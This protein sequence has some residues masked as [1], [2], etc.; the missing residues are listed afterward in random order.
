[1]SG[2]SQ[3]RKLYEDRVIE[4][5]LVQLGKSV[6]SST[7][8][9]TQEELRTLAIRTRESFKRCD[10]ER[11]DRYG[12]HLANIYGTS[13]VSSTITELE[14]INNSIGFEEK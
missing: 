7:L 3:R 8:P 2:E 6:G 13:I 14:R 12:I 4:D 11:L 5:S 9:F 1:M 10:K